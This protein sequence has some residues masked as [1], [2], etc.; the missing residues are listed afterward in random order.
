MLRHCT[1]PIPSLTPYIA[2]FWSIEAQ[3][4]INMPDYLPGTGVE[5]L[6]NLADDVELIQTSIAGPS[7]T[8]VTLLRAEQA[9][10]ICPRLSQ[11]KIKPAGRIHLFSVRFRSAGFFSLFAIPLNVFSD[12]VIHI[13]E[14]G[15]VLPDTITNS[16]HDALVN[17][18]QPWFTSRLDTKLPGQ[19]LL[20]HAI[21]QLYYQ[22]TQFSVQAIQQATD[23]SE[24]AFQRS[25]KQLTGVSAKYFARTARFQATLKLLL[26]QP[27]APVHFCLDTLLAQGYCDQSHFIRDFRYFT[28]S[29]PT[30]Y[31]RVANP[32]CNFY[33]HPVGD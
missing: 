28:G 1:Y 24:R 17:Q 14:L 15:L 26:K 13:S 8:T 33:L 29:T 21:D 3:C 12:Q 4:R 30:Q 10:C 19:N 18:L 7:V 25:V 2:Q 27:Q 32:Q 5:I 23:L 11:L 6:L 22:H 20:K 9:V 16:H 31:L